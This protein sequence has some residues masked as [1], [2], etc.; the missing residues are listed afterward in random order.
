MTFDDEKVPLIPEDVITYIRRY[1]CVCKLCSRT[2]CTNNLNT[3]SE[4]RRFWCHTCK[5]IP[6][7]LKHVYDPLKGKN[8][9]ICA[10]CI[11]EIRS[12][13]GSI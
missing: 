11:R 13:L 5:P 2:E 6:R 3:C 10:W 1:L 4:C 9:Y 12:S 8:R 7:I